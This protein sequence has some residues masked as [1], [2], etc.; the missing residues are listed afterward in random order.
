MN[1]VMIGPPGS[2][3]GT[4]AERLALARQL[5]QISTGSLIRREIDR[6]TVLGNHLL[7]LTARGDLVPD[8]T[9]TQLLRTELVQQT[10]NLIFDGYPRTVV[11]AITLYEISA[12]ISHVIELRIPDELL[13]E[14][15]AGR[16]QCRTCGANYHDIYAMPPN[17]VCCGSGF[18]RRP[19]DNP[20]A[21]KVRLARYHANSRAVLDMYRSH[22]NFR[23]IDAAPPM[24]DVT[25]AIRDYIG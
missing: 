17:G 23:V 1:V 9:V 24:D 5:K 6:Q 12:G 25:Q 14:R 13:V 19:E 2:G 20:E 11:Q 21:L 15:I 16:F 3:K 18:R 7:A 8:E 10:D 22:D 4:Q